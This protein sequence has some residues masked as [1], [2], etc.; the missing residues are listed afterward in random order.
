MGKIHEFKKDLKR[1]QRGEAQFADLFADKVKR[2]SGYLQDFTIL[3]NSRTIEL[4]CD[5][6]DAS[7]TENFFFERFS[8]G[9]KDGGPWQALGK[10]IDYFVYFF[11]SIMH[12]YVFKTSTLVQEL[13]KIC[14]GAYLIG[15]QN[16]GYTTRGYKVPRHLLDSIAIDIQDI[17]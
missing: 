7:K 2:E 8:Y 10:D 5:Y 16:S 13:N 4:K 14:D 11:P 1:G 17:L 12:F 15:V 6:Y 3:K 9:D